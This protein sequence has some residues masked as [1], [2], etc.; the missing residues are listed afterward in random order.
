MRTIVLSETY[1]RSSLANETNG[2]DD[3]NFSRAIPRRLSAEALLD[4]LVQAT[5]VPE[6]FRGAPAGFSA[7]QLPDANI[8][9]E[10]LNL[11]GKPKRMESCECERDEGSNMLQA[12]HF[13]NGKSILSRVTN[14]NG[15][16]ALLLREKDIT[17]EKI[18]TELYLWSLARV[19][20]QAEIDLGLKFF[21]S[22]EDKRKEAAEDLMWALLNSKD[23]MLVH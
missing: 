11:F 15:R 5:K 13:I 4:S 14:G 1:Q 3:M 21:K 20:S 22:Y 12:L 6:S 23:F 18:I 16:V 17:N 8:Q 10:F 2:H 7:K 9:S 19:A